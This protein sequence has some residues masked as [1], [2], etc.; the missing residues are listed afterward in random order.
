MGKLI[1]A[2][3]IVC[4]INIVGCSSNYNKYNDINS[5]EI[6]TEVNLVREVYFAGFSISGDSFSSKANFPYT[7]KLMSEFNDKKISLLDQKIQDSLKTVSNSKFKIITDKLGDYKNNEKSISAAVVMDSEDISEELIDGVTKLVVTLR[8]RILA[9]N[10]KEMKVV[11]SYPLTA[12]LISASNDKKIT[13]NE[14]YEAVKKLYIGPGNSFIKEL[15]N[16]FNKISIN[17]GLY[18]KIQVKNININKEYIYLISK[19]SQNSKDVN[20][21]IARNFEKYLSI[22]QNVAV[23]PY[24]KDQAVGNRL[25][26]RFSNGEVYNL[27]IPSPDYE[28]SIELKKLMKGRVGGNNVEDVIGYASIFNIK[29]EQPEM[30]KKYL[31][32]DVRYALPVTVPKT[33]QN[34]DDHAHFIE[35][36]IQSFNTFTKKISK[37]D[38][39]WIETWIESNSD[40][41][42]QFDLLINVI[43][44]CR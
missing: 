36:I 44:Q 9:F 15:V 40:I 6:S 13:D 21:F 25:S 19:K 26:S 42:E 23:L 5:Q 7:L 28:V 31:D 10:F 32:I 14:I 2:L 20:Q 4:S 29:A 11:G 24:T 35:S 22:N 16:R 3:Y 8:G 43:N 37:P 33:L 41:N 18:N 27:E 38:P 1:L 12:E 17:T 30:K 34:N 39:E